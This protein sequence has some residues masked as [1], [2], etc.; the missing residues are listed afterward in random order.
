M[1]LRTY[2]TACLDKSLD[3]YRAGV[4]RQLAVMATGLGKAILFA[5]L[6]QHH[7]FQKRV[8]VLVHREELADQAADK[9]HHWNPGLMLG[10]EMA[11]RKSR[12]MDSYVIA[13]VPT[14]G[15]NGSE[16]LK[17][18]D[19]AGFDCVV[20]D[21]AHHSCSPQWQRVLDYFGLMDSGGS[22]LSLGL[23]ATPNRSDGIGLRRCFDEIVFDMG[24]DAG[25]RGGYL[26][27]LRCWRISTKE[28]LDSV[29]TVAGDFN[30]RDLAATVNTPERNGMIVK[31]WAQ[32][33]WDKKSLVFTANIQHALDLAEAFRGLGVAAAA[34]WGDDPERAEKL[35]KHRAGELLVLVNC[36]VLT[37]GYD[38]PNIECI[39]LA[40]P[41]KSALLLTQMIGRGTR[42]P[43]ACGHISEVGEDG[44][45]DCII[46][47]V[48]DT[49]AKHQLCTVPSLLGLPSN[50]DLKG[51]TYR[52]AKGKIERVANEFPQANLADL[53][54]LD[55]LDYLATQFSLFQVKYPPEIER[56]TELSWRKQGDG[57]VLPVMRDRLSLAR[58]LRD[59]W[60]VRGTLNG[61]PVEIHAQNL[62]GAFNIA[63]REVMAAGDSKLKSI[64]KRDS[65]WKADKPS[66]KQ[67]S[68]CRKLGLQ[69]PAGATRGQVS[70]ALD[71]R[72]GRT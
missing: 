60:W 57:Y 34:V 30:E 36:A 47:D 38:D 67:V 3:R 39:V 41:T 56:L 53:R 43:S 2:Q 17:R 37:E 64:V 55:K 72:L 13:S 5:M 29:R 28:N 49:T 51:A 23:T 46:L 70:A 62:A 11:R 44:K 8:M 48:V 18:F 9:I 26:V 63:D 27:D 35:R 7:G 61:K 42:L 19:P 12:E 24:I 16:R 33:A 65:H 58:D 15:R 59:E 6:R 71:V 1:P 10:V 54:D 4:N 32:H 40:R 69:V 25:I 52:E 21:E 31:A 45:H 50:I 14:L 20:S 22:I 68:L 66:E